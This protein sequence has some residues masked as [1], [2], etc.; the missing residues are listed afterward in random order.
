MILIICS[1]AI[2]SSCKKDNEEFALSMSSVN[3]TRG[4]TL[5]LTATMPAV[6]L[7]LDTNVAKVSPDG[8]ITGVRVGTTKITANAEGATASCDVTVN[9]KSSLYREPLFVASASR[10]QI[11]YYEKR[12]LNKET[13]DALIYNGENF[14]VDAVVY[15]VD[16]I[17]NG[18]AVLLNST[19]GIMENA[20]D[21]LEERYP[22]LGQVSY[23]SYAF[24][25]DQSRAIV[26]S[27][28][29]D[30]GYN[31]MYL[32]LDGKADFSALHRARLQA[33]KDRL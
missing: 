22:Y 6:Y 16:A 23:M 7:S 15:L 17:Y 5:R 11:K 32:F 25:V 10:D 30:L 31:V 4:E 24:E 27:Y 20:Y 19:P 12:A 2:I 33:L 28:D 21:F 1:L 14:D 9:P 8:V 13:F 18:S 26:L 3:L 29:S